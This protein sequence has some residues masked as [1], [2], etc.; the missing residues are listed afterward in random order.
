M[1]SVKNQFLLLFFIYLIYPAIL[2]TRDITSQPTDRSYT[3]SLPDFLP[4]VISTIQNKVNTQT[5]QE[6]QK[7]L[8]AESMFSKN[9][10]IAD[11][12]KTKTTINPA[13]N[14]QETNLFDKQGKNISRAII[15][16]QNI[17]TTIINF[18]P[19][20]SQTVFVYN[21]DKTQTINHFNNLGK[22]TS[23]REVD[24]NGATTSIINFNADGTQVKTLFNQ[25]TTKT[26][27]YFDTQRKNNLTIEI[28]AT[29]NPLKAI[30]FHTDG[31]QAI[32]IYNQDT[33]KTIDYFDAH[34]NSSRIKIDAT[35]NPIE[36]LTFNTD[37]THTQHLYNIDKSQSIT[38]IDAQGN[39]ISRTEID[40][41]GIQYHAVNKL[42]TA[43]HEAG[44]A[45]SRIKNN[46]LNLVNLITIQAQDLTNA[47]GDTIKTLGHVRSKQ[48]Y[49]VDKSVEELENSII[50]CLCG[51]AGEQVLMHE[52]MLTN[53]QD[54]LTFL[55]GPR[56]KGDMQIARENAQ[57]I[58]TLQSFQHFTPQQI[59]EK[60]TAIIIKLYA[61]AYAFIIN[62]KNEVN[63]IAENL[64]QQE[65]LSSDETYNL[66]DADKPLMSYEQGPLPLS[67]INDYK[68][69][70]WNQK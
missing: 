13:D 12:T 21:P 42:I 7:V 59:Q 10:L 16:N 58:V 69:R 56:Y 17:I 57:E 31:S 49:Q 62:N 24:M 8:S 33:T 6:N 39:M 55:S 54:I 37:G 44:H 3:S 41:N 65:T 22:Q 40:P 29:G 46:A 70:G 35:G 30:Q 45:L 61:Q 5:Q 28:D 68:Y 67:L 50:S 18:N 27:N 32:I 23:R 63:K 38:H 2:Q 51:A 60:I 52:K 34:K 15:N 25:D 9:T 47:Q 1:K 19:D 26:I 4:S 20:K 53:A 66:I 64:M 14:T 11:L 43:W 36:S 48:T